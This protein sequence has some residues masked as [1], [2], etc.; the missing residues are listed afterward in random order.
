MRLGPQ[1]TPGDQA[2]SGGLLAPTGWS[3]ST[4]KVVFLLRNGGLLGPKNA[5]DGDAPVW[6]QSGH[7]YGHPYGVIVRVVS[8]FDA[9][10]PKLIPLITCHLIWWIR[11]SGDGLYPNPH[12]FLHN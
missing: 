9:A 6:T 3:S 11:V 7:L 1:A 10:R 2:N 12:Q 8:V 5:L 4:V